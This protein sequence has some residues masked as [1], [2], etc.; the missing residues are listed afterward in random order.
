MSHPGPVPAKG[1]PTTAPIAVEL[2]D[3]AKRFPGV[4]ANDGVDLAV[5]SGEVHA[6]VGE[7]GAGK[8]TLM[9]ILYG[10]QAPDEGTIRVHGDEVHFK[11]PKDA[12]AVGIGMVHQHFMLADNLTVAENIVLGHEPTKGPRLDLGAA[13]ARIRELAN[14]YGMEL[15]PDELVETL[16]V[17][18]RQRVE[19]LK[20]LYRGA[21]ILILDEPTAVLVP[22]EVDELFESLT[23]LKAEGVT[24][25]FISHKLDEVLAVADAI[26]VIRAGGQV[27]RLLTAAPL[28]S[29]QLEAVAQTVGG[30]FKILSAREKA[31]LKPLRIRVVTVKPGE[32]VGS[33]AASMVGVDRKLELFRVLNALAPGA[34]VS[35]GDKVKIV[36]DR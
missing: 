32:T 12:I 24:V 27:Y 22:H 36:T 9:K 21:R 25:I 35:A 1:V 31:S 7:N 14:D 33:V 30:S 26:T 3:I 11:S 13:R 2:V 29:N 15:D 34:T 28:A 17:G 20:V 6:V 10:M 18:E 23:E 5:R 4:I 19:I 16:T 8:S